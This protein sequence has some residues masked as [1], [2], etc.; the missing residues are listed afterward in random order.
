MFIFKL[1]GTPSKIGIVLQISEL[2]DFELVYKQKK[3]TYSSFLI[4]IWFCMSNSRNKGPRD[5]LV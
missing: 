4:N 1:N 5:K 3:N 2:S